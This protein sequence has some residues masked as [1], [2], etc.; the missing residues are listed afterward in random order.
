ARILEPTRRKET[1]PT[2]L[3]AAEEIKLA[4]A[5]AAALGWTAENAVT[6][7]SDGIQASWTRWGVYDATKFAAY[8]TQ[9]AIALGVNT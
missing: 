3:I 6:L 4:R 7:Y 9:P 5:E 8:M 2:I 1:S